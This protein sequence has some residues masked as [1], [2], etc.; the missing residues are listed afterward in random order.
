MALDTVTQ[1][2]AFE[3]VVDRFLKL[4]EPDEMEIP[5]EPSRH[6]DEDAIRAEKSFRAFIPQAWHILEPSTEYRGNWHIDAVADH[7]EAVSRGEILNLLI[8]E[9]PG[10][11]KSIE[12]SVLFNAWEWIKLPWLRYLCGSYGQDLST[13]D[14]RR[15]RD[16]IQ[17]EWYQARWPHVRLASDQNQKT[18]FDTTAGGW[19]IGTSVGGRGLGEHPDRK[20]IDDPHNTKQAESDNKRQA[21]IDWF[22]HM[23]STRGV[24][25]KAATIVI[26]QRLHDQDL[27]G[28]ILAKAD[29]DQWVHLCLPMR[30]ESK[31]MV[32][33]P[34]GFND[35]RT[36]P[37]AL[38]WPE[39]FSESVVAKLEVTMGSY[40]SAGQLQQR[41]SAAEGGI[42]KRFWWKY[43]DKDRPPRVCDLIIISVDTALKAKQLSD[44]SAIQAWGLVQANRF[45]LNGVCG[46]MEYHELKRQL[47]DMHR[48]VSATWID[49]PVLVLIENTAAGPDL[50]ADLRNEIAGILPVTPEGDKVQRAYAA[51]P[52]LESGNVFVPGRGLADGSN[53]DNAVTPLWVQELIDECAS[54][55]RGK[56]DRVD[57]WSQAEKEL[58]IRAV[59][60]SGRDSFSAPDATDSGGHP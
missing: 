40:A 11:M 15:V 37:G 1:P 53:Y 29:R 14:N 59:N 27:S 10:C 5:S 41:P 7:L 48:W 23:L 21:A 24:A 20:I 39:V 44:N 31:R 54:F 38:L 33:T 42:I 30:Y 32:T 18:R 16:L 36:E 9:P 17:S 43:Y 28:H 3:Q 51:T 52:A 2:S 34:L 26:A 25:R 4:L 47:N 55:P 12:V 6:V 60:T 19:R 50:I 57:T 49:T 35:P 56:D 58:K 8:N 22:D 45:L 46:R 13:R